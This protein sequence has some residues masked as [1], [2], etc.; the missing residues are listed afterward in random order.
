MMSS[1]QRKNLKSQASKSGDGDHPIHD[2]RP[3]CV[4]GAANI[5]YVHGEKGRITAFVVKA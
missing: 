4:G 3:V 5:S 2:D 1:P